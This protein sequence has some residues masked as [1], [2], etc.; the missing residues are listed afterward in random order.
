MNKNIPLAPF[1]GGISREASSKGES[2]EG[3][4]QRG[5]QQRG[6]FKGGIMGE[7]TSKGQASKKFLQF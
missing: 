3:H 2:V 5:N 4:L 7:T 1:K 6:I